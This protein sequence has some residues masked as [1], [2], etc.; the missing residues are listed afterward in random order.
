MLVYRETKVESSFNLGFDC[1]RE[2]AS[3][4]FCRIIRDSS[5]KSKDE[6][7]A[8]AQHAYR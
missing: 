7:N 2:G 1:A 4:G 6:K 8:I 5:K 3:G